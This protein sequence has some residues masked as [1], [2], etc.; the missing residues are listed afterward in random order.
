MVTVVHEAL[1]DRLRAVTRAAIFNPL[2][3]ADTAHLALFWFL[4]STQLASWRMW[5]YSVPWPQRSGQGIKIQRCWN[6][7]VMLFALTWFSP[8]LSNTDPKLSAELTEIPGISLFRYSFHCLHCLVCFLKNIF[9]LTNLQDCYFQPVLR[10]VRTRQ[11]S[12]PSWHFLERRG[13]LSRNHLSPE[14][15]LFVGF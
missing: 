4:C 15:F 13:I 11:I 3:K 9:F 2:Y 1:W 7:D 8:L 6:N 14:S 5:W 12:E 10:I